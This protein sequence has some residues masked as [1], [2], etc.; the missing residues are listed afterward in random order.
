MAEPKWKEFEKAVAN[1]VKALDPK[2]QVT[3][4][5]KLPDSHTSKPRQRDVWVEAKVCYHF[6]INVLISCKRLKRKLNQKDIDAFN[7]ELFSSEA[8]LGVLY[9]YSGFAANAIEK[10]KK[11]G[12]S[13][14]KLFENESPDIPLN[15]IFLSSYCCTPRI[16]LSVVSPLDQHWN[17]KTWNDL[18]SLQ[19]NAQG[20]PMAVIDAIVRSY[21]KGEKEALERAKKNLFPPNWGEILE[22][23][24]DTP[25][26]KSI[27]III[28][29]NW[30]IYEGRLEAHLLEGSYNFTSGE[31]LGSL[32]TPAIDTQ[33]SHPG[34][35]WNLLDAPPTKRPSKP[36]RGVVI[37]SGGNAKGP[38]LDQLGSRQI[39]VEKIEQSK[40]KPV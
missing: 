4:D 19:F 37:L 15:L 18:F 33:S 31:F 7:G 5:I 14:C 22:C 10:A 16:S 13:C 36:I 21:F 38:L 32:S 8:R 40:G 11:L 23:S 20:S 34:P 35:G 3:H 17:I 25:D 26:K 29:G 1:F 9:S 12:I 28:R 30:N 2:A 24:E 6:P 39:V 27:K